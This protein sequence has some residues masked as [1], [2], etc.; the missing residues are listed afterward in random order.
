MDDGL[1]RMAQ[2]LSR[3]SFFALEASLGSFTRCW[4]GP[5]GKNRQALTSKDFSSFCLYHFSYCLIDQSQP[6]RQSE[7]A[8]VGCAYHEGDYNAHVANVLPMRY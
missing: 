7:E 4:R 3:C 5:R 6:Q 1:A 8:N 2:A